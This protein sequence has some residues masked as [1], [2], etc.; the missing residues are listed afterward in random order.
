MQGAWFAMLSATLAASGCDTSVD[1]FPATSS[2]SGGSEDATGGSNSLGGEGP[3]LG[4]TESA[5]GGAS[6]TGGDSSASAGAPAQPV[7]LELNTDAICP[8]DVSLTDDLLEIVFDSNDF[9]LRTSTRDTVE[10]PWSF[11]LPVPGLA[12]PGTDTGAEI[13]RDGLSLWWSSNRT[14]SVGNHDLWFATRPTRQSDWGAAM[15]VAEL[16]STGLE[17]YPT[18]TDDRLMIVFTGIGTDMTR[19]LFSSTRDSVA[20][21]WGPRSPLVTVNSPGTDQ[22]PHLSADGLTLYFSSDRA[23]GAGGSDLYVARRATREDNFSAAEAI[24]DLNTPVSEQ[25][26]WET[27]DGSVFVFGRSQNDSSC[28]FY[29]VER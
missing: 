4:G 18:L 12:V 23:G 10:D 15:Q 9:T 11:A 17:A 5:T 21:A 25:D 24:A 28:E 7:P 1:L 3:G 8:D 16:N 6:S 13:S 22:A 29:S 26:P 14:G 19:D 27:S 2:S 20:S